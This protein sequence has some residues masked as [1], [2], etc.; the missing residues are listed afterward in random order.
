MKKEE[1]AKQIEETEHKLKQL[2]EALSE[3][4]KPKAGDVWAGK[5]GSAILALEDF[6]GQHGDAV[7]L[8]NRFSGIHCHDMAISPDCGDKRLGTFNEVFIRRD[9]VAKDYVLKA[10]ILAFEDDDGDTLAECIEFSDLWHLSRSNV[11]KLAK[12]LD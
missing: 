11:S 9:E 7:W 5:D 12:L 4:A 3:S 10:D 6:T 8:E 1:I 2:R